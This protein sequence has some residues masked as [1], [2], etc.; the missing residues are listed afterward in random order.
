MRKILV[1]LLMLA[2]CASLERYSDD[3]PP[4]PIEETPDASSPVPDVPPDAPTPPPPD[5]CEPEKPQ[6]DCDND[7]GPGNKCHDGKCYERCWCDNDCD[8]GY[9]CRYG[10]CKPD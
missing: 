10:I 9:D 2:G 1:S 6:C 3:V 4:P 7:C 5:S 8:S